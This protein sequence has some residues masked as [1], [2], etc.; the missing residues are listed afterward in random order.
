MINLKSAAVSC[1]ATYELRNTNEEHNST[2]ERKDDRMK[3]LDELERIQEAALNNKELRDEILKTRFDEEPVTAFCRLARE[4]GYEI[5]E[6]DLVYAGEEA[7]ANEDDYY[8]L[9]MAAMEAADK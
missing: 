7:Y 3:V 8:S 1:E 2:N 6:M 4:K 5:Y 9:F